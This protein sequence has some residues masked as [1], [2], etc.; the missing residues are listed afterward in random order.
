MDFQHEDGLLNT[1]KLY[2]WNNNIQI[3]NYT[4]QNNISYKLT[5]TT[6]VSM[7]INAQIRQKTGPNTSDSAM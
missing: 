6:T 5:P 2:S 3:Y 1:E 7:N 4:F